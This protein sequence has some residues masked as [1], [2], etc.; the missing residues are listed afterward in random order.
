MRRL[1]AAVLL[2]VVSGVLMGAPRAQQGPSRMTLERLDEL[3]R[4]TATNVEQTSN[5][6]RFEYQGIEVVCVADADA[7]RMRIIS[8][9]TRAAGLPEEIKDRMLVA[10]Y[11]SALDARYA[12]GDGIVYSTFI[13]PLST[14][15]EAQVPDAVR[16]VVTLKQTFGTSY[17]SSDWF[18]PGQRPPPEQRPESSEE[19]EEFET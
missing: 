4:A 14:L 1:V 11:H 17:R 19:D 10:N 3:I 12:I 8:A 13:H 5:L 16:Q 7:D 2:V 18:M 15:T 6:W 9:V